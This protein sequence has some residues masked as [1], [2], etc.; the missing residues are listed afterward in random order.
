[1][2]TR[3]YGIHQRTLR[4]SCLWGAALLMVALSIAPAMARMLE[5]AYGNVEIEGQPERVVTLYEGALDASIALGVTPLGAVATR[6]GEHVA[7]YIADEVSDISIV[8]TARETNLE[9]VVALQPDMI[10]A[11]PLLPQE[12]YQLLSRIAPVVVPPS[13]G[14]T[15]D[16]WREELRVFTQALGRDEAEAEALIEHVDQRAAELAARLGDEPPTAALVRWMPQ[17]PMVMNED[18]FGTGFIAA[19]GFEVTDAGL[20]RKGVPHSDPLSLENLSRIDQ[21]WMFLATLNQEG[22]EALEAARTSPAFQRLSVVGNDRVVPVDGQ[23]FSSAMG[24]LAAQ[25]ILDVLEGVIDTIEER[26]AVN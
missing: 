20:V 12:Q 10:L 22:E 18:L 24:P 5:T 7:T 4:L 17:G 13:G 15:A 2:P 19:A 25:A 23:L 16:S 8:G 14:F 9:A 26:D 3:L 1:M 21:D 11:S 6:G